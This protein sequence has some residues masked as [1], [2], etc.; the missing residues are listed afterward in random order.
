MVKYDPS[1]ISE[2]ANSLYKMANVIVFA[3]LTLCGLF[4]VVI[5]SATS[6]P[7]LILVFAFLGGAFGY[8]IGKI[9]GLGL[10]VLAQLVLC[11]LKIEENT[12]PKSEAA[13][14]QAS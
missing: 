4:G 11:Q 12:R 2:Y 3:G 13:F 1:V 7:G 10:Q 9:V 8:A 6:N 5:G 14:D